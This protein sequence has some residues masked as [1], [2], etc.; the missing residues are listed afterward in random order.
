MRIVSASKRCEIDYIEN[1]P[2]NRLPVR[3]GILRILP[4]VLGEIRY[5]SLER[6]NREVAWPLQSIL[7]ISDLISCMEVPDPAKLKTVLS[8]HK[9]KNRSVAKETTLNA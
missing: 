8:R 1:V 2:G 6:V 9:H 4:V 5:V 7:Q 3:E